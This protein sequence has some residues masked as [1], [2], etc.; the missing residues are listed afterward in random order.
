MG[1]EVLG[2]DVN[3]SYRKF[4]VNK[5]GAI[6]FGMAGVKGVGAGAVEEIIRV[7][8]EGGPFKRYF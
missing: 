3:E 4:T 6:R 7:R 5:E 8:E 1:M 2:P